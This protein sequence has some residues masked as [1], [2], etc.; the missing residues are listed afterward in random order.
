MRVYE[1][2]TGASNGQESGNCAFTA[3]Y[4]DVYAPSSFSL[5]TKVK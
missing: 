5:P 1:G 2:N 3:V 4:R